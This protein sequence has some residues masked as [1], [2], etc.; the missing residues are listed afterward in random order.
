MD[1][2]T[3]EELKSFIRIC[4]D[5]MES[6]HQYPEEYFEEPTL[7]EKKVLLEMGINYWEEND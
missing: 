4:L 7:L 1:K 6:C 5:A 3:D 2:C